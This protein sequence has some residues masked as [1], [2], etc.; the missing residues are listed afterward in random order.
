[1]LAEGVNLQ[2]GQVI[3]NYDFHWNPTRLIQI[4][5]RI[6]SIGS[7]NEFITV[8]NFLLD[9]KMEEDL[10]LEYSVDNKIDNIQKIIGE[11]YK[12]LKDDEQVTTADHYAIYRGDESIL[13]R[14]DENPLAPSKFEKIL[15]EIQVKKP[16]LWE[17]FKKIPD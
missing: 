2:A 15:R 11:D 16:E 13:A 12:I 17:D 6:D 7:K 5:G 9:P 1:M 4:A 3:I 10:H 14:E 8:H